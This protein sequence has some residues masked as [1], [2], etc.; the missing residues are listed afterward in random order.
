MGHGRFWIHGFN[1]VSGHGR[2]V[3]MPF[4]VRRGI[5]SPIGIVDL[6]SSLPHIFAAFWNSP[7]TNACF[8][9][10]LTNIPKFSTAVDP[11]TLP[12]AQKCT[13]LATT[14]KYFPATNFRYESMA[15]SRLISSG[16]TAHIR[17]V[18][19]VLDRFVHKEKCREGKKEGS[20]CR[21]DEFMYTAR[22]TNIAST[23]PETFESV[24]MWTVG[25]QH[26]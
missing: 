18:A 2:Y 6:R 25:A 16:A 4:R 26:S 20:K 10:Q 24:S 5:I 3:H 21:G 19:V 13:N 22:L 12:V 17:H 11:E 9:N 8:Q 1:C 23:C 15:S 7:T 14:S